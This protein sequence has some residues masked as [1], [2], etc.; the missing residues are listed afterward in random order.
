MFNNDEIFRC[1]V[2][3]AWQDSA[4]TSGEVVVSGLSPGNHYFV[5]SIGNHCQ[6]GMRVNVTVTTNDQQEG[7]NEVE[8]ICY[9]LHL[10]TMCIAH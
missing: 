1:Q 5:C 7:N 4:T 9:I 6:R 8:V 2:V 3:K 10:K